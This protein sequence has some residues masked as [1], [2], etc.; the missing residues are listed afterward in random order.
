[1]SWYS[2]GLETGWVSN[3]RRLRSGYSRRNPRGRYPNDYQVHRDSY[4]THHPHYSNISV[5]DDST[6]SED[7]DDVANSLNRIRLETRDASQSIHRETIRCYG[8]APTIGGSG[9]REA[10]IFPRRQLSINVVLKREDGPIS[11]HVQHAVVISPET[12]VSDIVDQ[13]KSLPSGLAGPKRG[14]Y[15]SQSMAPEL[16][17]LFVSRPGGGGHTILNDFRGMTVEQVL[18]QAG[19]HR[20]SI[21]QHRTITGMDLVFEERRSRIGFDDRGAGHRRPR[22]NGR[23]HSYQG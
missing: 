8:E 23:S 13:I 3:L 21:I 22:G 5:S 19:Y 11:Q 7:Y 10:Y 2:N 20:G 9:E 4:R 16:Y 1:M 17:R 18:Q 14:G 6:L 15:G 12:L